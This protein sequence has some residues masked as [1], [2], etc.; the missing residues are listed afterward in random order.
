ML[1]TGEGEVGQANAKLGG[2]LAFDPRDPADAPVLITGKAC[3]GYDL[4]AIR[5]RYRSIVEGYRLLDCDGAAI[6]WADAKHY[7]AA[8]IG[9]DRAGHAIMLHARAPVTMTELANAVSAA[10]PAIAGALFVEGGPEA[11]VVVRGDG[12]RALALLGSYETGFHE[13][14]DNRDFWALPN[15]I[16]A[17][18]R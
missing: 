13:D 7:S 3:A 16:G 4:A 2:V 5:G 8:A 15:V 1:V 6:R 12:D 18:A 17:V 14:D 10:G 9:V 11:S